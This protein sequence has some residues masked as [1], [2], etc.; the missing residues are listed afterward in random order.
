MAGALCALVTAA[1]S[2]QLLG[3]PAWLAWCHAGAVLLGFFIHLGLDELFSVDLEGARLKRSFGTALKLGGGRPISTLL[4][5][6]ALVLVGYWVPP[7]EVLTSQVS[8]A[9][10]PWR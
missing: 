3:Q 2:F 6:M 1:F 4:M 7:W 5:L 10:L 9:S 8:Q